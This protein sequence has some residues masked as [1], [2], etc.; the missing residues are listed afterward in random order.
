MFNRKHTY[1]QFFMNLL[2]DV[3]K[4]LEKKDHIITTNTCTFFKITSY[5]T[6]HYVKYDGNIFNILKEDMQF[7][8]ASH[9]LYNK[10]SSRL[11]P[12]I[13]REK[14]RFIRKTSSTLNNILECKFILTRSLVRTI[15]TKLLFNNSPMVINNTVFVMIANSFDK[16]TV[17]IE[18][19][20]VVT[21]DMVNTIYGYE[22]FQSNILLPLN[23]NLMTFANDN[24]E[25]PIIG[26]DLNTLIASRKKVYDSFAATRRFKE[27][28][29]S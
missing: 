2:Q 27:N 11:F 14:I 7:I 20:P 18:D 24:K 12:F 16:P 8:Q 9:Q 17:K 13:V 29:T 5:N 19:I 15:L 22:F 28:K 25:V 10:E 6:I 21:E 3:V 4:Y 26:I 1:D 23:R